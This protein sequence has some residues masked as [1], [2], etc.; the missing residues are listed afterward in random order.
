MKRT[1]P[2]KDERTSWMPSNRSMAP[3]ARGRNWGYRP[4]RVQWSP[5]AFLPIPGRS[6]TAARGIKCGFKLSSS[7]QRYFSGIELWKRLCK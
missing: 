7:G 4:F 6:R 1:Q 5:S 3:V 2:Q